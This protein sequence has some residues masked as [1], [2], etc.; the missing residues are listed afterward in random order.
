[1]L[2]VLY[3]LCF[4][5]LLA[6]SITVARAQAPVVDWTKWKSPPPRLEGTV[7]LVAEGVSSRAAIKYEA[8]DRLRVEI[9]AN[10][11]TSA[12]AQTIVAT[13]G[14]TRSQETSTQRVQR[15]PFHIAAQWWRS[16]ALSS[17]SPLNIW[18]AGFAPA[19]TAKFYSV[20]APNTSERGR[21]AIELKARAD[22][23]RITVREGVRSGGRGSSKY[24]AA[25]TRAAFARPAR[26]VLTFDDAT[27][28]LLTRAE[29]DERDRLQTKTEWT[30]SADGLPKSV[31]TRDFNERPLAEWGFEWKTAANFPAAMWTIEAPGQVIEDAI[32]RPI[33]EYRAGTDASAQF[34]LGVALAR[35]E[36][37]AT[38][39]SAFKAANVSAPRAVAPLL[40]ASD[41]A[42]SMRDLNEAHQHLNRLAEVIGDKH[43][44]I[45]SRRILIDL[46]GHDWK[47]V[48]EVFNEGVRL[49][50]S[51]VSPALLL[52]GANFARAMGDSTAATAI[53]ARVL[54]QEKTPPAVATQAALVL[55]ALNDRNGLQA[56]A[57]S[58]GEASKLTRQLFDIADGKTPAQS[59]LEAFQFPHSVAA[60]GVALER[61]GQW[62]TA[63][64]AWNRVAQTATEPLWREAQRHLMSLHAQAGDTSNSLKAY[65]A[66]LARLDNEIEIRELQDILFRSWDKALKRDALRSVL[67]S[68]AL[69]TAASDDDLRL[70]L[71][72]QETYGSDDDIEATINTSVSR[73]TRGE[74][75][76]WWQ[77]RRAE[78]V[79]DKAASQ[80]PSAN[81]LAARARYFRDALSAVNIAVESD[82][83]RSYYAV[84][85]ALILARRA[86]LPIPV[87]DAASRVTER[88]AA[89][90][91]LAVLERAWPNDPDVQI[92]VAVQQLAL[93][94]SD[95]DGIM[96]RLQSALEASPSTL[97]KGS[98]ALDHAGNFTARQ[99]LASTLRR[100]NRIEASRV[101]Y[102]K[103]WAAAGAPGE[104]L[105]IA[106]NWLNLLDSQNDAPGATQLA[107]RLVREPR[108]FSATQDLMG[109][110]AA[111]L[112]QRKKLAPVVTTTLRASND[113]AERLAGAYLDF[114]AWRLAT[115]RASLENAPLAAEASL[116]EASGNWA[117]SKT[118]LGDI[119][120]MTVATSASDH[121]LAL[122]A[123]A[124][125]AQD[126][127]A[128]GDKETA[129]KL[130]T[131]ANALEPTDLNLRIALARA[132][133]DTG[134]RDEALTV[135]N[136]LLTDFAHD[137][138]VL[139]WA[140]WITLRAERFAEAAPLARRAVDRAT[141]DPQIGAA[142]WQET[143]FLLARALMAQGEVAA[144]GEQYQKLIGEPWTILER[145]AA[146]LD[147]QARATEANRADVADQAATRLRALKLSAV[148]LQ[149]AQALQR[150]FE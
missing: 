117:K 132:L 65:R 100:A 18:L 23:E 17:G 102:E 69:A 15:L 49:P 149:Q 135:R 110:W 140:A 3:P 38:A 59:T 139:R 62:E 87:S 118:A 26:I 116:R 77:S 34:N 53:L 74:A 107:A 61:S 129:V 137:S 67:Q 90:D 125:L 78:F 55:A 64:L 123:N 33:A 42:R 24:Y 28:V 103:L 43:S 19:E 14:E 29:F 72:W 45:V 66:L 93:S 150:S 134:Q 7:T 143:T 96:R 31:V 41:A 113:K 145:A 85:R 30:W 92:A 22:V 133:L 46:A 147:W 40:A 36:D 148:Q 16:S 54:M 79:A 80:P 91:A 2:K 1:M 130:F 20:A 76:A 124:L 71:A 73:F 35:Q 97:N 99:L 95:T 146:L 108:A 84:Q 63:T 94:P 83:S 60:I 126:A 104:Q 88:T 138:P 115:R 98:S 114:G 128:R 109:E 89:L 70:W 101:E 11:V 48:R 37:F 9:A 121:I 50:D 57:G 119:A 51:Q 56:L 32:L 86:T 111:S 52:Q 39:L 106:L 10:P 13:E 21:T 112:L 105:G 122:Q 75:R 68:R 25:R 136:R 47:R 142:L 81:G 144:A 6:S 44:E 8:P 4:F 131:A 27:K 58:N 5:V 127:L 82:P 120:S 141:L 12:A